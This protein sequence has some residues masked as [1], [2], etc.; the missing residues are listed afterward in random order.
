MNKARYRHYPVDFSILSDFTDD[1]LE[2]LMD[3]GTK[4]SNQGSYAEAVDFT[5]DQ[6][7]VEIHPRNYCNGFE[8]YSRS[9]ATATSWATAVI[10]AAEYTYKEKNTQ[11]SIS[12]LSIY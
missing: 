9:N 10:T 7:S 11:K 12:R 5:T 2:G 4:Y 1:D 6:N 8:D 3:L